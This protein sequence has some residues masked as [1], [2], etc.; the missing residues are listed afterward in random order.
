MLLLRFVRSPKL[1][2]VRLWSK[3]N[4][5]ICWSALNE[6]FFKTF[7]CTV[8][9]VRKFGLIKFLY[10]IISWWI[11]TKANLC[12][13]TCACIWYS[14]VLQEKQGSKIKKEVMLFHGFLVLWCF[15]SSYQQVIDEELQLENAKGQ[16]ILNSK[17]GQA[18]SFLR[19]QADSEL[20]LDF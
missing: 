2:Q 1:L 10:I 3:Q 6:T 8:T 16:C 4:N 17:L 18:L 15:S 14:E 19:F 9:I 7:N 12:S 13:W 11:K 20:N 5:K